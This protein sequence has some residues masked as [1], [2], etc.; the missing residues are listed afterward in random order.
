MKTLKRTICCAAALL[1]VVLLSHFVCPVR[2]FAAT[3]YTLDVKSGQDITDPLQDALFMARYNP[4]ESYT[5]VIPKGK[6]TIS[7]T[8]KIYSD[9]TLSMEG[10]TLTRTKNDKTMLRFGTL[11]ELESA[12]GYS[13]YTGFKNITFE[14]G[15]WDGNKLDGGIIR[16]G[17][18]QNITLRNVTFKDVKNSHHVEMAACKNVTVTGC[19]F[20]GFSGK[21][22]SSTNYEAL[23]FDIM[24]NTAHFVGYEKYDDT[25]CRDITVTGCTFKNL[26]RGVGT[27]SAVAGSYFTNMTISGNTFSSIEG[28]AIITTNYRSS[29]I[30]K[31]KITN[32]GS[33]IFFRSMIQNHKNYYPPLK[34]K[35][36][37]V[38]NA[39]SQISSNTISLKYSG[40][41]NVAF[42]IS[43]YGEELKSTTGSTKIP[44]GDYRVSGVTVKDNK[45]TLPVLSYGIWLQGVTSTKVTGN[46][47]SC[48]IK[49]KGNK[50]GSGDGIRAEDSPNNKILSNKITNKKTGTAKEVCGIFIRVNCSKTTV[51]GNTVS[52]ATKYGIGVQEKCKG[53]LVKNNK[54]SGSGTY[55]IATWSSGTTIQGNTISGSGSKN[56]HIPSNVSKSVRNISNKLK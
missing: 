48:N 52:G 53:T 44:A 47:I 43:L 7:D 24:H 50:K 18:A 22:G 45:I 39:K 16:A 29:K 17:H 19:T 21:K 32:C 2:A 10:A 4:G 11:A 35:A 33:G 30:N 6:Y 8:L 3:T 14:G 15:T 27:H 42:G 55:G 5:I 41:P 37:I 49:S 12:G 46:T 25:P 51:Q 56:L 31:N 40:Y 23:Q 9:T 26:Q 36:K 13:G 28:Y 38:K 54:V 20:S 1:A 34:G